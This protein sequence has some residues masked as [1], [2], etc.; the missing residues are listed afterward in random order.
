LGAGK[1][2]SQFQE[3]EFPECQL[4]HDTDH[5]GVWSYML[6]LWDHRIEDNYSQKNP[7]NS[8]QG[9]AVERK[10]LAE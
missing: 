9:Y 3:F 6:K 1:L 2:A 7:Q 4:P 8:S 10:R 5:K